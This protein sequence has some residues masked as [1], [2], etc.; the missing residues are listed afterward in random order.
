MSQFS[1][2][3]RDAWRSAFLYKTNIEIHLTGWHRTINIT[4]GSSMYLQ[5][6]L[7]FVIVLCATTTFAAE[8]CM[9]P[10]A[11]SEPTLRVEVEQ[12]YRIATRPRVLPGYAGLV[13]NAF[14]RHELYE[15]DGNN[16]KRIESDFP[17]VWGGAFEQGIRIS[18][19][20]DAYGLGSR[21]RVVFYIPHGASSWRPIEET[22]GYYNAFFDQGS[23]ELYVR[24]TSAGTAIR[25]SGGVMYKDA[26]LP[27]FNEDPTKSIRTIPEA[28]GVMALTGP[29]RATPAESSSVWFRVF[30]GMWRRIE[31]DLPEGQRIF[32]N[33]RDARI[34]IS[35]GLVR[36]FPNN[37]A[38]E[39]LIFR[40]SPQG[41][42]FA[43]SA[44]RGDW[45]YHPSS[46]TWIGWS[47]Q[48][49]Q[50]IVETRFG[51]WKVVVQPVLPK[52]FSLGPNQTTAQV[53]LDLQPPHDI[54]G[55]K[56][57]YRPD[58]TILAGDMPAL[59]RSE[60]GIAIFD[61]ANFEDIEP[62]RYDIIGNF[63][64]IR[65]LGPLHLIQSENGIFLLDVDLSVT[66]INRFPTENPW[67]PQVTIYYVD[68]WQ[69]YVVNDRRSGKVYVSPDMLEFA[70]V[71]S[72]ERI[73]GFAGVLNEPAS[74]LAVGES[75]LFAI[76]DRCE[77]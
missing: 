23:G 55:T 11:G 58:V 71:N 34:Q 63:P 1:L 9:V 62:L 21:P 59:V 77:I 49:V 4:L 26:K 66:R 69:T 35:N 57:F 3:L 73:T 70:E 68:A 51:F 64:F 41:L 20:H 25:L 45:H 54:S 13:V 65:T 27:V 74:V 12:P 33:L 29:H 47:G 60:E 75:L 43:G 76:T 22:K 17:H 14:N 15:F 72:A 18:P 44:P 38:F 32:S 39:P 61:G 31:I 6:I 67:R 52:A 8:Y 53:I 10:V 36:V 7:A 2:M 48:L 30:G 19:K 42:T 16:L 40:I 37:S 5:P 46:E 24:Q 56:I 28:N 50:P